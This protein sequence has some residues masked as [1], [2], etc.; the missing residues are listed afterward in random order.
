[1]ELKADFANHFVER[2]GRRT[3]TL[4]LKEASCPYRFRLSLFES[5]K[6]A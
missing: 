3:Y 1:M 6:N 4:V 2:L 5:K